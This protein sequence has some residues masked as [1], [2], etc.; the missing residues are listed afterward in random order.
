MTLPEATTHQDRLLTLNVETAPRLPTEVPGVTI[1]PLFLDRE[2][3][4]WVLYGCFA[5]GTVLPT[6]FHTGTVHFYTTKGRWN[7]VEYPGDPQTAGSYL[8]EPGGSIHTFSVP[9]EASEAAEGIMVVHGANINFVGGEY[10]SIMDAGAIES[11]ILGA[12]QAGM[13]PMPRYIRPR[14]GAEFSVG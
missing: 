2:N 13:M 8:Y 11:A 7:Y 3:G 1:T 5:P 6:H 14:G 9:A 4:V 10:H 12:V